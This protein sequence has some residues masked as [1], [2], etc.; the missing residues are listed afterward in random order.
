MRLSSWAN[1]VS[2]SFAID[3]IIDLEMKLNGYEMEFL[4]TSLVT[5]VTNMSFDHLSFVDIYQFGLCFT[6]S[7]E[8]TTKIISTLFFFSEHVLSINL[9]HL[10]IEGYSRSV[11]TF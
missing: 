3:N 7:E 11:K 6:V 4:A 9:V 2:S 5:A 8:N 10:V 1:Y